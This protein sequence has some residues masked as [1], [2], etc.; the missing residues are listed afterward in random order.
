MSSRFVFKNTILVSN[1]LWLTV[2]LVTAGLPFNVTAQQKSNQ[3]IA[4]RPSTDLHLRAPDVIPG[5]LPEMRQASYWIAKMANPDE[6]V[7][8]LDEIQERNR[9]YR[10][11]M[12]GWSELDSGLVQRIEK[13]LKS[14]PGLMASVPDL[15]SMTETEILA[16][17]RKMIE[18]QTDFLY[19]R[20]FGNI[21]AIEYSP[22]ELA[23]IESEISYDPQRAIDVQDGI[24]IR[25][26]RLHVIPSIKPE[27]IGLFT[28]GKARWDLWKLDVLPIGTPVKVLYASRTGAFRLVLS[29]RGYGWVAS[30]KV[31]VGS[32]DQIANFDQ[33]RDQIVVCTGDRVPFYGDSACSVFLGWLRMGDHL[34]L[35]GS[36]NS[37]I[38]IPDRDL[39]GALKISKAWLKPKADVH[40]G[41]LPYTRKH[42]AEQAFKLL[43]NLYDW[44]GAWFGRNHVTALRD[45]YRSFGF[46]LPANGILLAAFE[47]QP[48]TL[49]ASAGSEVQ[50][51]SILGH[52]PFLTLQICENSH[53]QMFLGDYEGMPIVFDAHGYSYKDEQGN[54]LEIKRWVVGT[55]EMPDYF[56]KQDITFVKLY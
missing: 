45:I 31:A 15:N 3:K 17:V 36:D 49:K 24:T 55:M 29:A 56:L 16:L 18:S 20:Q 43:D 52:E 46:Q 25:E 47:G 44:T 5:T 28:K 1:M 2:L 19:S 22:D 53:S 37:T 42:T 39:K 6:V 27:Q 50:F 9:A 26:C 40:T 54:D 23:E 35:A 32:S 14:R 21:M 51:K 30:E 33:K 10:N 34:P 13:Q 8:T 12:I 48:E 11:R 41:Y 38:L 4:E 7:L